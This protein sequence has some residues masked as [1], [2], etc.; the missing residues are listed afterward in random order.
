M[1][2]VFQKISALAL[3]AFT[4]PV[5]AFAQFR[6]GGASATQLLANALDLIRS[7][8][9]PLLVAVA[10]V[11][12]MYNAIR[13]M[14]ADGESKEKFQSYIVRSLIGV[15]VMLAFWGIIAFMSSSTGFLVGGNPTDFVVPGV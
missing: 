14:H 6:P 4:A 12:L 2:K 5:A 9:I 8:I 1:K 3:V 7:L 10:V 11:V 15:F 13:Y